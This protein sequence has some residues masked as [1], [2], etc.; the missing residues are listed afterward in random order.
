MMPAPNARPN[1]LDTALRLLAL[2]LS[3]IPIRARDKK[4]AIPSWMPYQQRLATEQEIRTWFARA[5]LNVGIVTGAI[6]KV[7]VVD[8]DSPE[9]VAW[10]SSNHPSPMRT[11]TGN[12]RHYFF[13]HPGTDVRNGTRLLGMP[14]DVRGDGGYVVAPGSIHPSGALYQEDGA[15]DP[16][17][18]PVFEP[19]WIG[20]K[21]KPIQLPKV[22]HFSG[23][24]DLDRR[25]AR[26]MDSTPPAI[27]GQGGDA[28]TYR[29]A[30]KLIR[31]FALTEDQ[32]LGHMAGWNTRCSP[33]W[34]E[35]DLAGK[36]RSALKSGTEPM[37]YLLTQLPVLDNVWRP[38][39]IPASEVSVDDG[40]AGTWSER[41]HKDSK[42]HIKPTPGNLMKILRHDPTWGPA[43]ALNTMSQD[44]FFEGQLV[45]DS[46]VDHVQ[47]KLED[48]FGG[49]RWGREDVAAKI[50]AVAECHP[51][52]PVRSWLLSLPDW[53]SVPRLSAVPQEVLG[54]L[55]PHMEPVYFTR[56]MIAAVRRVFVPAC[57]LHTVMVLGG[58]QGI[59][60]SSFWRTLAGEQWFGDTPLDLENKDAYQ[61]LNR[62]W[63]YEL[64]EIDHLTNTR[65]A[66][67]IKAFISSS[68]DTYRPPYGR[69]VGVFPR[70]SIIVGTTNR[71]QYHTDPTGSR[72]FW[73]ISVP[74]TINLPLLAQWRDQLWAEALH[75]HLAGDPHWLDASLEAER[76]IQSEAFEAEDPW[77]DQVDTA[78]TAIA[79]ARM[80]RQGGLSDG[81]RAAEILSQMGILVNQQNRGTTMK[82]AEILKKKGWRL[83]FPKLDGRT[84]RV[85]VPT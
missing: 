75:L 17:V 12:G 55:E 83:A 63:I 20:V 59:G 41:L 47:E 24:T 28:H 81:V 25:V 5:D 22:L 85:W 9:A 44:I 31:G 74:G 2:G 14:L 78:L 48:Q 30:C 18:L 39:P 76:E 50:R 80:T 36:L 1:P 6:S 10:L 11:K 8:A 71:D 13:R 16:T 4:P 61:V 3:V 37:G 32:A 46:F 15:W 57:Q 29:V 72:R 77:E 62:R 69:T 49:L 34:S 54:I 66:E 21:A 45:G 73:S 43:L 53:D 65:A 64:P 82:L 84:Q 38:Q 68:E 23:T 40:G 52:H 51:F 42:G 19:A 60:K 7:V 27:E 67:R 33:P 56:T 58:A 26:Y 35:K 79:A 70:T